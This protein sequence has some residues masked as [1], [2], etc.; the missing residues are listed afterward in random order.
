MTNS[1]E[2]IKT[3]G[4]KLKADAT[5][6]NYTGPDG[7]LYYVMDI[8]LQQDI[9]DVAHE[10]GLGQPELMMELANKAASRYLKGIIELSEE[11]A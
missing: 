10:M 5:N 6:T 3:I 2:I 7:D 11:N 8:R 9:T 4:T 1:N